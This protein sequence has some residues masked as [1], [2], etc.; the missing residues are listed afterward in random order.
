MRLLVLGTGT[1]AKNQ[2]TNFLAIDGVEVV[3]AVDTDPARLAEFAD[4]FHIEKRFQTLEEA[5]AWG[6]FDAATNV[7]PDRIHHPTSL[8]LIA[9]GK[10]VFCEKPLAE[11]YADALEMTE[12]AEAAGVINMVNLTYRNVAPLQRAREMVLAG[13]LGTIRH[14][15]ASYLQSWLVSRAWGD[16][17]T[18]S[19]WLWRLSTGHGSNGVLG[20]VGI[21]ILDFA[22]YGAA[23][24]IDHV[25]A[26]LKTFNKAPGG[27]IGEYLLDANDSFTMSVDFTNGA[28]GV[29]HA[30]R[31]A[32]GHLNELKLRIYGERGSLEV[33]HRPDGS[34]LRGCFGE[35]IENAIWRDIEVPAVLTNYQRFAEAVRTG[36]QDDPTFRHAAN[37]QK[38]IDLAIVS[39]KERRELN[40]LEA[41]EQD[42]PADKRIPPLTVV[43]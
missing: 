39:E 6:E 19:R 33:I 37:L 40:L 30:T 13:E 35:D 11:H 24:D 29:I 5:I 26:R 10:H 32:T 31:W 21:H 20:D 4:H 23:T 38:V 1:M 9:A 34:E 3:G 25:F 7:T 14:V 41:S 17:R 12:A 42:N 18:E 36:K 28:L 22:A 15:E 2:V 16:W 43:V 8:A 27:Q